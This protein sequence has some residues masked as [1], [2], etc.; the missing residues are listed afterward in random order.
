MELT[1]LGCW[2]PYPRAGGAC[3]G[4]LIQDGDINI[5][6]D[7]GNGSLSRLMQVVDFRELSAAV[8][9]HFHPDHYADLFALRHAVAGA[10]RYKTRREPLPLYIPSEPAEVFQ[11]LAGCTDAF[12][13]LA[14]DSLPGKTAPGKENIKTLNLGSVKLEFL[15][16]VHKVPCYAVGISGSSHFVYTGDTA[17]T[18]ELVDFAGGV[19]LLL[20]EASG[21]DGD[22]EYLSGT[23]LTA[24]EAGELGRRAGAKKVI[25]T[26]FWPEYELADLLAQAEEGF[27][28]KLSLARE[29]RTYRF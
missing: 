14:V 28:G 23:H 10:I 29:G 15:P 13:V 18:E 22:A 7:A 8:I 12:Q 27:N 5:M 4:Y 19:D 24:R 16:T 25:I 6:L 2:A 3:S 1:V 9:S 20:S 26:H 21:L 11:K 17:F